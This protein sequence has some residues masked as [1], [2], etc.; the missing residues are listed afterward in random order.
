MVV[1]VR[2]RIRFILIR[3]LFDY[4]TRRR[5]GL[6]PTMSFNQA[7][8]NAFSQRLKS[9]VLVVTQVCLSLW[10]KSMCLKL[11]DWTG[12]L[13]GPFV[14]SACR[15]RRNGASSSSLIFPP[16][17]RRMIGLKLYQV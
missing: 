1:V 13:C 11:M 15:Q 2:L 14:H 6:A 8:Y 17:N 3:N 10:T 7:F 5:L 9:Y 4:G 16:T 12:D